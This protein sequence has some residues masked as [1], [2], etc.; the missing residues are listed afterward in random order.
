MSIL[1][2]GGTVVTAEQSIRADVYCADGK[3]KQVGEQLDV[4]AGAEI[5]DAGGQYVMPG[6]ID[7]HTHM[8]LPF[9]GT[10]ASEDFYTGTAAGL[11]GGTTS[12]IDF[13]IPAPQQKL[14]DAF[15][16]WRDWSEKAV[17]DYSFHVAVTWWDDS[18]YEDMG[19]LVADHG[20]NSFKHFMAYKNA[21]MADDEILVN[22][23]SRALELGAIP[24]GARGKRRAGV[25]IAAQ[26][27]GNGNYRTGRPSHVAPAG[28]RS[29][30]RQSRDSHRTGARGAGL[31]GT[32]VDARGT[33]KYHYCA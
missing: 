2:K 21:I 13:V 29:G 9:M 22:S 23:F 6:G 10:V 32:C 16:Q 28:S 26:N 33:A 5:V 24:T 25:S 18:V 11:A 14:M 1:I 31:S 27:E 15:H 12:I 20:V 7:P 8:Q 4:P 3:I 19:K 17:S 30:S